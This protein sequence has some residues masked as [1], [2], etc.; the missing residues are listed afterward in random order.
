[1]AEPTDETAQARDPGGQPAP[2]RPTDPAGS[3]GEAH[4]LAP[5]TLGALWAVLRQ[6]LG[7]G[8]MR[9]SRPLRKMEAAEPPQVRARL[10]KAWIRERYFY[11]RQIS[12]NGIIRMDKPPEGRIRLVLPYD[13]HR[14]FSS[15]ARSDLDHARRLGADPD[16]EALVGHLV[17][18]GFEHAN[19]DDLLDLGPIHGSV[20]IRVPAAGRVDTRGSNLL[21]A[22]DSAC[23]VSHDY[24]PDVRDLKVYPVDVDVRL[25]DPDDAQLDDVQ[26][27]NARGTRLLFSKEGS[28]DLVRLRIMRQV[29]FLSELRLYLTVRLH[30]P[31]E[32]ATDARAK[33]RQVFI[34]WPTHTSLGS[35]RLLVNRQSHGLRYNP[36]REGLEWSD[37]PMT[38][39]PDP[40]AGEIRTFS[41]P[42]MVLV[43][44][45]PGELYQQ[46]SLDGE[47]KVAVN[48][49][50]SGLDARLYD[51]TG[52]LRGHPR[53]ARE[54]LVTTRFELIL[55]DAFARRIFSPHQQLHFDEV[56]P[57]E[58]RIDDIKMALKNRG[59][60]ETDVGPTANP[61]SRWLWAE[62]TEGPDKLYLLLYVAGRQ[63]KSRR[64]R[65]VPGGMTY[66]TDLDSGELRI[67]AHGWLNRESRPVVEEMNALRE[68]LR[69]RFDRL[70]ARR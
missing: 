29:N 52:T 2:E 11:F 68:A 27:R 22:D 17:L 21:A 34:S 57:A 35:L 28:V 62:R 39:D 18:T 44:P 14:Y 33:V 25:H 64:Q 51:A 6:L 16:A 63:Y 40:D 58:A 45:Q 9:V 49:L 69:E 19:L 42:W 30:V 65:R 53:V 48:R 12:Q 60:R 20:P 31:R 46:V 38:A 47:V 55:G 37:I 36:E 26:L 59:F 43:I 8:V 5:G 61:E 41:S 4:S 66:R 70:P 56:I 23:V 67:Y 10:E 32:L 50:L 7:F 54:S 24:E 15:Q 3:G 1:M 13:G